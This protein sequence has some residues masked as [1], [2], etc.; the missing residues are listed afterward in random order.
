MTFT[1]R[2]EQLYQALNDEIQKLPDWKREA[3]RRDEEF[4][5]QRRRELRALSESESSN[6]ITTT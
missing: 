6:V 2:F 1:P 4:I 5:T 3:L